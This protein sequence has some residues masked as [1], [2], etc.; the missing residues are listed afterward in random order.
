M[1]IPQSLWGISYSVF[2]S[3]GWV[4]PQLTLLYSLLC[5]K[6]QKGDTTQESKTQEVERTTST[7]PAP[8][9]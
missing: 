1:E 6:T 5:S 4:C 2:L 7:N 8:Y 3:G 9:C